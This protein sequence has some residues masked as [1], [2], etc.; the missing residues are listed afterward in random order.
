MRFSLWLLTMVLAVSLVAAAP[1]KTRK[2]KAPPPRP[3]A[4]LETQINEILAGPIAKTA[5]WGIE[6]R[7][8]KADKILYS[9]NPDHFFVP[10]SNTKLFT[11]A[12]ALSRLGPAYQFHTRV[13]MAGPDLVLVGAGDPNLS[14]RTLPYEP[15]LPDPA[16][17]AAIN[18]LAD[19]IVARGIRQ[20]PGSIIGDDTAFVYEPYPPGWGLTDTYDDDGP[21]ISAIC[22]D[23]NVAKLEVAPGPADGALAEMQWQLPF[24]LFRVDNALITDS[25]EP[26]EIRYQRLPGSRE[27]RV[28]GSIPPE[29]EVDPIALAVDDPAQFAARALKTALIARGVQVNGPAIAR[30]QLPGAPTLPTYGDASLP[31][32]LVTERVSVP[33]FDAIRLVDKIS[34][35][36]HAEILLRDVALQVTGKGT[37]QAGLDALQ[38]FLQDAEITPDDYHFSD[39]SGLS[40]YNIVTPHAIALLLRHMANTPLRDQWMALLPIGGVDG[41]LRLRFHALRLHGE[42]HAKT[43][44]LTHVSALSGYALRDDGSTVAFSI[45]VNNY[46]S[47]TSGIRE[48]IDDIAAAVLNEKTPGGRP[49]VQ[50]SR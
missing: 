28:W 1:P 5:F 34:Q 30:H 10:A 47:P 20:I 38:S 31:S 17:L 32:T 49:A 43:G 23:D 41:S 3:S 33:L 4:P 25:E 27:I 26:R 50:S 8:L 9:L 22:V 45:L 16:P 29:R 13:L 15:N 18:Q 35:N 39:G 11:T 14:G 48:V 24:E 19:E 36:L 6:I 46:G 2:R 37:R 12:L 21:P 7:D 44:S 40:R 42:I